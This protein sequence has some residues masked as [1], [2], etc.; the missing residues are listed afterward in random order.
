MKYAFLTVFVLQF[1]CASGQTE[2]ADSSPPKAPA[3][4]TEAT[5]TPPVV[6]MKPPAPKTTATQK[7]TAR[8]GKRKAPPI[9]WQDDLEWLTWSEARTQSAANGKSICLVVYADW[10]PRCRELAPLFADPEIAKLSKNLIMVRQDQDVR[11]DWL[12]Q[13]SDLGGYVPRIFFFGPDGNLRRD[14]TSPHP[15]Y[16]YFYTPRGADALK[17]SMRAALGG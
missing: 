1:A 7:K 4:T 12:Q 5:A 13:F 14:I 10:C 16:P 3:K 8:T 6:K 11:P 17:R 15:R 2:P 9:K